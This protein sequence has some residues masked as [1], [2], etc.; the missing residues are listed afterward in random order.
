[1]YRSKSLKKNMIDY[2]TLTYVSCTWVNKVDIGDKRET[3]LSSCGNSRM[4]KKSFNAKINPVHTLL[5]EFDNYLLGIYLATFSTTKQRILSWTQSLNPLYRN[6][7]QCMH[8]SFN[9]S[10]NLSFY[11]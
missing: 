11:L 9:F 2:K 5:A 1:M 7:I 6:H 10:Y 8:H 3:F 4:R